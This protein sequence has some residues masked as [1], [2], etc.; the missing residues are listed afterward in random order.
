MSESK[1]RKLIME[2]ITQILYDDTPQTPLHLV[3][4]LMRNPKIQESGQ[5]TQRQRF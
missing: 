4:N 2:E 3:E 1:L 5:N